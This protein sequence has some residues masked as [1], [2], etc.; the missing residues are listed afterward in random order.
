MSQSSFARHQ[1]RLFLLLV[2]ISINS[3]YLFQP[4]KAEEPV[5]KVEWNHFT[6]LP[7]LTLENLI[8][9]YNYSENSDRYGTILSSDFLFY[10]DQQDV[11]DYGFPVS[12]GKDSEIYMRSLVTNKTKLELTIIND[13]EDVVLSE[14][15]LIYRNY[16][17]TLLSSSDIFAGRFA[18]QLKREDDG[19]WRIKK[20]EDFRNE[21]K[22]TWGRF[23]YETYPS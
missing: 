3:C 6:I 12:W 10:F 22:E 2:I 23:K 19:F 20:W 9:S 14:E 11:H 7:Y 1:K 15:A 8:Y 16:S 18:L 4:R 5:G 17:L 13:Q 21:D